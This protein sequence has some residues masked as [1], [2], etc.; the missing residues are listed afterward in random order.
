MNILFLDHFNRHGGA[1]EYLLEIASQLNRDGHICYVTE[2]PIPSLL[3]KVKDITI[4]P[5]KILTH[6]PLSQLKSIILLK[7]VLNKESIDIIHCN[8]IPA[9]IIGKCIHGKR[10]LFFTAHDSHLPK[11]KKLIIKYCSQYI[12][13]VSQS[14]K[15]DAVASGITKPNTVV[16]NGLYDFSV[17]LQHRDFISIGLPGRIE[18]NKGVDLFI[19]AALQLAPMYK[20]TVFNIY[21]TSEDMSFL[22]EIKDMIGN[23]DQIRINNFCDSKEELYSAIDIVVNSSR[24][25]ESLGRTLIEAAIVSLPVV[26]PNQGGPL[27]VVEN[28][29]SGYLFKPDDADDLANK[30]QI[31]LDSPLLRSKMGAEGRRIFEEKFRINSISNQIV[32]LYESALK[33]TGT[34]NKRK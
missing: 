33:Y 4:L 29:V 32:L 28:G 17:P 20:N 15:D 12:I 27:E 31:L 18:R 16:H 10:P 34:K 6:S 11:L 22:T 26:A 23:N 7:K 25:I 9:L 5:I 30:I 21:G 19:M 13:S 3:R 2:I 8:S 24:C 14:A 1:Q